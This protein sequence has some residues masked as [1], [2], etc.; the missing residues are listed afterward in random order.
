MGMKIIAKGIFFVQWVYVA[1][2]TD[3]GFYDNG[4]VLGIS[5]KEGDVAASMIEMTHST[6]MFQVLPSR[7]G[8]LCCVG[9]RCMDAIKEMFHFYFHLCS[10]IF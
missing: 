5:I 2:S 1:N 8:E 9:Y 6:A 4:K 3:H 7:T 10:S